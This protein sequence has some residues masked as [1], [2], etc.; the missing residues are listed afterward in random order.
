MGIIT[1]PCRA[2]SRRIFLTSLAAAGL[3]ASDAPGDGLYWNADTAD[4]PGP[5]LRYRADAQVLLFGVPLLRRENVGGGSVAWRESRDGN[6]TSRLLEFAAFSSP[7]RA[8]GLNRLGLIRELRRE[9][10]GA[11]EFSYFGLMTASPEESEADARRALHSAAEQQTFSAIDGTVSAGEARS[12]TAHFVAPASESRDRLIDRA[13]QA[14][15]QP[16]AANSHLPS[17]GA[18]TFL[19]TLAEA[20]A[21]PAREQWRYIYAGRM[22]R[23]NLLRTPDP[24]AADLFRR[25]GLCAAGE[26]IVRVT[27]RVRRETGGKESEFRLWVPKALPYPLPLRIEYQP[28]PY[29]RLLFEAQ[30][31]F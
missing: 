28:K 23:M 7:E 5:E 3:Q 20:V 22:Y 24:K 17:E 6:S 27:G 30:A 16:S 13:R 29:L 12:V 10:A 11:G 1:A 25:R 31:S 9:T 14:I 21:T 26:E 18:A 8:A 15:A 19:H 4:L 2:I